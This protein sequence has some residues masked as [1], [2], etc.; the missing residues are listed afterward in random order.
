MK[1]HFNILM[2]VNDGQMV[3]DELVKFVMR[4][5]HFNQKFTRFTF[6]MTLYLMY[7]ECVN[8]DQKI[9]VAALR[10]RYQSEIDALKAE[11][12]ELKKRG[13]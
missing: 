13:E 5:K 9:K 3:G 8:L 6:V 1:E 4:Q 7:R 11:I 2:L 12:E 10:D